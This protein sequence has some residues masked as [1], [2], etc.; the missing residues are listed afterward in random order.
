LWTEA[1][2]TIEAPD[3]VMRLTR[4][5][6]TYHLRIP[7]GKRAEAERALAVF[8]RG[9]PVARTLKGCVEIAHAWEI[10]EE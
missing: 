3:R 1:E 8:E 7:Q 9:C 2:G 4:M 10:T 6:V 5:R